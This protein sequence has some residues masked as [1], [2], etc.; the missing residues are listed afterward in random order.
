MTTTER[1]G[2]PCATK[3]VEALERAE[4]DL[5]KAEGELR[6]L[7]GEVL[8]AEAEVRDAVHEID[9]AKKELEAECRHRSYDLIVNRARHTWLREE[10]T[11]GDIKRLARSPADWVVNQIVDGPGEDPE[12]LDSEVVHLALDAYPNGEKRFTTR[13]PKTTPGA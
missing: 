1:D 9:V 11:G 8:E 7:E 4:R 6:V 13:K 12:I 2:E 10:I 3:S 5:K